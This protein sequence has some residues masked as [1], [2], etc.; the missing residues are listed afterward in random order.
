MSVCRGI[1]F[2]G[3]EQRQGETMSDTTLFTS[4]SH[5]GHENIIRFCE[6]PFKTVQDMDDKMIDRWNGLVGNNDTVYHLGDFTLGGFR[7][8]SNYF[9]QLNGEIKILANTFH[10]DKRWLREARSQYIISASGK[11]VEIL[12]P[13]I[14][15]EFPEFGSR[16]P[17]ALTLCHFPIAE[18]P[19][20][21]HGGWHLHGHSHGNYTWPAGS[22]AFDIG[23]DCNQFAPVR[24]SGIV[25]QMKAYGWKQK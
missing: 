12:P 10:H 16:Y 6:R 24:L 5:F 14:V 23:V 4:D 25:R 13:L 21:H 19:R 17:Q 22:L 8:A 3:E 20:K 11:P 9:E 1:D 7:Q 15:L 2:C 18:W